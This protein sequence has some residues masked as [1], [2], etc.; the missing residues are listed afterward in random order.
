MGLKIASPE[1][2]VEFEKYAV[3]FDRI[4]EPPKTQ[5][6]VNPIGKS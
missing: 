4:E 6:D 2:K 5:M 1:E 3:S